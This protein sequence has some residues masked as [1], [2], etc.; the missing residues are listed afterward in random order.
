M[1][2][3]VSGN[4]VQVSTKLF[5]GNW[6][7]KVNISSSSPAAPS[8]AM[9]GTNA[10][11][12]G[13]IVWHTTGTCNVYAST[14]LVSSGSWSSATAISSSAQNAG[15]AKVAVDGNAKATAV[16]Y[17]YS[18][19]G[20][21]YSAVALQSSSQ[22]SGGSWTSPV[23]LSNQGIMNPANLRATVKVDNNG[24]VLA[25]WNNSYDGE[26]FNVESAL[27]PVSGDWTG[28]TVLV[29]GNPYA[30]QANMAVSSLGDALAVYMFYNGTSLLLQSV[31]SNTTG[32][33]ENS[34]SVPINV[35][36]GSTNGFPSVAATLSGSTLHAV[37]V[38]LNNNGSH[39]IVNAATGTRSILA[40]ATN[41]SATQSVNNFGIFS[42]YQNTLSWTASTNPNVVGYLIF[43]NGVLF[44]Q[45]D[46]SILQ[47]VDHNAVQNQTVTYGVAAIDNQNSQSA[48]VSY[49]L[50]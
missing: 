13:V 36:M 7:T 42:E 6:S 31:E 29:S 12:R 8:I 22:V 5:G 11:T 32:F 41:L 48:I 34:W 49:T 37:A 45:V 19:S 1:V 15:F 14:K 33:L 27:K 9:G 47:I 35:S 3:W 25:L 4:N 21:N 40:P 43:R 44:Q 38:W 18:A 28:P 39:N 50:F 10:N 46:S 26:T 16:W 30:Y 17:V 2:A 20:T 23:A 24:N